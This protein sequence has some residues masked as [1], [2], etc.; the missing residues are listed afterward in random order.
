VNDGLR[1]FETSRR[2]FITFEWR[3]VFRPLNIFNR[4]Y[5]HCFSKFFG[6]NP[7]AFHAL[8]PG[9]RRPLIPRR[10]RTLRR[11]LC[12]RRRLRRRCRGDSLSAPRDQIW[13]TCF[14]WRFGARFRRAMHLS[15]FS[16]FQ[17]KIQRRV[18]RL[19]TLFL[20]HWRVS[21]FNL[22]KQPKK[23]CLTFIFTKNLYL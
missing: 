4:L 20:S 17:V 12:S 21:V 9:R 3:F 13:S 2:R 11:R 19:S 10:S 1:V 14:C 6:L 18:V 7:D 22:L 8:R 15:V 5:C 16:Q 23:Y